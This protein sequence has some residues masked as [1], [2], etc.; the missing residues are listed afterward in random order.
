MAHLGADVA[1]FVD[2]QL[3]GAAMLAASQHLDEC[4]ECAKAVRQQRLLKSR[5]STV[6]TPEPTAALLA[7]LAGLSSSPPNHE[8]WWERVRRSVPFRAGLVVA[9]A[10]VAVIVAA[11]AVGSPDRSVGDKVAPPFDLYAA[12]FFGATAVQ[13]GNVISDSA[14]SELDSA[15][16]PCHA[17]LAGD[18]ARTSGASID[19]NEV[20]ALSYSNGTATLNLFEQNGTLDHE[21]LVGF[22]SAKMGKSQVWIRRGIPMLVSWDYDGVVYTIVTDA[23]RG[24]IARAVAELP[25]GAVEGPA[26]RVGDGLTQ[27]TTWVGAA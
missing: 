7:S 27:M 1:A 9:G 15:G 13:A 23:D 19:H 6:A 16:W 5:M 24:R 17:V 11:Y 3:S 10:S 20:V 25:K 4:D 12:D 26:S 8:S 18:L 2:G 22:E 21:S 14:M